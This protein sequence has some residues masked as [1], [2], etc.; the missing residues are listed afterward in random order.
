MAL[1][2]GYRLFD[3]SEIQ[4]AIDAMSGAGPTGP[5]GPTGTTG[6]AGATG[7]SAVSSGTPASASAAGVAGTLKYDGSFL[8]VCT[9]TNTWLRVAIATW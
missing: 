4:A 8:Y 1:E 5:T 7:P 3:G 2:T 6:A 9:A